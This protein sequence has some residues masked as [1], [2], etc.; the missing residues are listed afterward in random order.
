MRYKSLAKELSGTVKEILG[1]CQSVGCSEYLQR[2]RA[3][4]VDAVLS[5]SV[6]PDAAGGELQTGC[7]GGTR[8]HE[9]ERADDRA[10]SAIQTSQ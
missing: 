7:W 8:R 1:T 9:G 6:A 2:A 4:E 3:W 10:F 5:A